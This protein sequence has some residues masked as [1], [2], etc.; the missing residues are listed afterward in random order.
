MEDIL[1]QKEARKRLLRGA[2][3][4][5]ESVKGTLGPC[6]HHVLIRK[7]FALPLITNDGVTIA[8]SLHVL[9]LIHI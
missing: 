7:E 6:G 5:M 1:F 3:L 8:K 4:L 2:Q 9:S